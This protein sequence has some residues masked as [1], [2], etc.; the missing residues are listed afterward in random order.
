MYRKFHFFH[1]FNFIQISFHFIVNKQNKKTKHKMWKTKAVFQSP[2]KKNIKF[3]LMIDSK[4]STKQLIICDILSFSQCPK[5]V[6]KCSSILCLVESICHF[7]NSIDEHSLFP[8]SSLSIFLLHW[9]Q[10]T[11]KNKSMRLYRKNQ[12]IQ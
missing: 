11:K 6:D 7:H 12:Q 8:T 1:S 3:L 2:Q 10:H 4:R 9:T 5:V